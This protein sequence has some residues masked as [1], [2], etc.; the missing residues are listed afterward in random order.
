MK[1][2][3]QIAAKVKMPPVT[4]IGV[5]V[6][7]LD[8]AMAYYRDFFGMGPFNPVFELAPEKNWYMGKESPLRLRIGRTEWGAMDFELVQPLEGKSIHQD[9]L[10]TQGEGLHHLGIDV[11]DFDGFVRQMKE[12][13]FEPMQELEVYLPMNKSWAKACYFDTRKVG[14]IIIEALYRPWLKKG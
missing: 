11:A 10:D 13:G 7:D 2:I 3:E 9:F 12:A 8:R 1:D 6:R 14:G 4:Q 5:V